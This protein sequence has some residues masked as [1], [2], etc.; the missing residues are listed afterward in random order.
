MADGVAITA[1]AGTTILTDDTGAGGHAQVMKLA[2]STDGSGVLIPAEAT[3]GLDV[4]V[5]RVI[6]GTT[7]TALGKAEDTAHTTGD[8]GV[9]TLAVRQDTP[10]A[11]ATVD[12]RYAPFEVGAVGQLHVGLVGH[13]ITS[14]IAVNSA[15]LTTATTAYVTGDVLGAE[16]SFTNAVRI[17][18]GRGIIESA[19]LLDK[20]AVIGAVDLLLFNAASTPASDNAANSWSDTNMELLEG[21]ISFSPVTSALNRYAHWTGAM[22]YQA[23]ATTLFGVLVTRSGHTFFGAATDLRVTLHVR[24]E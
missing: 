22:P 16:I 19:T 24:F 23:T 9:M 10:A 20:S 11:L 13:S 3:N 4:D 14:R 1:G 7:A 8:T 18:G 21:V 15:S 12:A 5:T 2:I 6:P 17:S